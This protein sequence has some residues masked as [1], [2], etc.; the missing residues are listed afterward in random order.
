[1]AK[2]EKAAS[3]R[4]KC[5]AHERKDLRVQWTS[6]NVTAVVS[7]W[8]R[9]ADSSQLP[10]LLSPNWWTFSSCV[11][12]EIYLICFLVTLDP[13]FAFSPLVYWQCAYIVSGMLWWWWCILC[14]ASI[15]P[16][17]CCMVCVLYFLVTWP[18]S[19]NFDVDDIFSGHWG[20]KHEWWCKCELYVECCGCLWSFPLDYVAQCFQRHF[21]WLVKW[22]E[23]FNKTNLNRL[24]F[25]HTC[26]SVT[27]CL[28]AIATQLIEFTRL[29][30]WKMAGCNWTPGGK[31]VWGWR[32]MEDAV[33]LHLW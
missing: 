12:K 21:I 26:L 23:C 6:P 18:V 5:G 32:K 28:R 2:S 20:G 3:E 22:R 16:S 13:H 10:P 11:L 17:E 33:V 14:L 9:A 19:V 1:M 4:R 8:M 7:V 29:G 15:I 25:A 31:S 27:W 30:A 24:L